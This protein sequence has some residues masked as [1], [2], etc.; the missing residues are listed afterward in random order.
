MTTEIEYALMAGVAYRSTRDPINRIPIPFG[1]S[2]IV[3]SFRNLTSGFEAVSFTRGSEIVISFAG[4]DPSDLTGDM[5]ANVGLAAGTGS[6]QLLQAVQYY[7]QVKAT[8]PEATISLTGHSLGGGLASLV[9]VFFGERAIT[10]DQAP[11]MQTALTF[12]DTNPDTGVVTTRSVAQDLR[13]NLVASGVS[14]GNLAQLDAYI[15]AADPSNLTPNAA[16]TL[17]VRSGQV[18]NTK[19]Q[20]EFVSSW[21]PIPGSLNRIGVE[22]EIGN[23]SGGVGGIDMHSQALLTAFLQSRQTAVTA[24]GQVQ[25]L[26]HVTFKLTDLLQM[27]FDATLFARATNTANTTDPNFLEFIVNHEVGRDPRTN[28]AITPDAMVTR[29]TTDMWKL[30]QDGGLTIVDEPQFRTNFLSR[31]LTAF[32]MQKYYTET[33]ASAGYGKTLFSDVSGGIQ[34]DIQDVVASVADAKGFD[35]FKVFLEKYYLT[36]TP[37]GFPAIDPARDQILNALP[38]LRDWYI[39][40]GTGGMSAIDT[41]NR[42]A[43]MFGNTDND[44]LT[45]GTGNDLL[46]G[47]VGDDFLT[48][49]KGDDI[50]IGGAGRDVYEYDSARDGAPDG[51]D[52]ILDVDGQG[53]LRYLY[54]DA[55]SRA[56]STAL[57]GVAIKEPDGKWKT[58][59]G[60][61][62]LE[63]TGVDLKV[64]FGAGVDG[65]VTLKDFDFTKAAQGGYLGIRLV[66]ARTAPQTTR[67]IFGDRVLAEFT[68]ARTQQKTSDGLPLGFTQIG[69]DFFET[70]AWGTLPGDWINAHL[71]E[72][73]GYTLDR[74]SNGQSFFVLPASLTFAYNQKDDLEN[75]V[76]TT[77]VDADARDQLFDSSG[78]DK[79]VSGGGN[80][81]INAFRGGADAINVG[82]GRDVVKAGDGNDLVEGGADGSEFNPLVIAVENGGDMIAGGANDDE[83]YGNVKIALADAI[84][85]GETDTATGAIGDFISGGTARGIFQYAGLTPTGSTVRLAQCG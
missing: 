61:F 43:F 16:D 15:F 62:V 55:A 52:T 31:A 71:A 80:D 64:S 75:L 35:D 14:A 84:R 77:T 34:F 6:I 58:A 39:Q 21:F 26:S 17:A 67:D 76:R 5:L 51:H 33:A 32:A 37:D 56:Q 46:V 30:A 49:R 22:T 38:S 40:A 36:L 73:S 19:V 9:A 70:P 82:A 74:V 11:F 1:W 13:A 4:T 27:I 47:N 85:N 25:S 57:A 42:N 69:G 50:L 68:G 24:G 7:L 81:L 59:D 65:S 18:T 12:T 79:I 60:R 28:S 78:N 41:H 45:G 72:G 48:G 53:V 29:F 66:E 20:G 3:D 63:Q 8:N 10:F 54:R 2:E 83:L 23:S 44:F